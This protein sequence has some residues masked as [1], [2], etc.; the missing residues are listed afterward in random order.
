MRP[1]LCMRSQRQ[2]NTLGWCMECL[3]RGAVCFIIAGCPRRTV[4]CS[5]W[6]AVGWFLAPHSRPRSAVN[7]KFWHRCQLT[8]ICGERTGR[9]WLLSIC[10]LNKYWLSPFFEL[11][12][13]LDTWGNHDIYETSSLCP[14][15][16]EGVRE[17]HR[18]LY[19]H[20]KLCNYIYAV[21]GEWVYNEGILY[22]QRSVLKTHRHRPKGSVEGT[23][24]QWWGTAF[25]AGETAISSLSVLGFLRR[26]PLKIM[27]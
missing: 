1:F 20:A 3:E 9:I 8:V 17:K 25:H 13:V 10:S 26:T 15:G 11:S 16:S 23:G 27:D 24:E 22:R 6:P 5:S 19:F 4:C 14:C 12:A 2:K 21:K 18:M 7:H